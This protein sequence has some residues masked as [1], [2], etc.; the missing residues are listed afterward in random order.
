[1]A[2]AI[3]DELILR[4]DDKKRNALIAAS[5]YN[6][7]METDKCLSEKEMRDAIGRRDYSYDGRFVYAVITTGVYCRPNC[8]ARPARPENI[9]F[10]ETGEEAVAAGYR[11]CKRCRPDDPNRDVTQM[12]ELARFIEVH[13][14]QKLTLSQLARR[15]G[16]SPAY[17]QR[18]FK[19]I[20][21]VSPKEYQDE[22]RKR[23]FKS[24]LRQNE[25]VTGA[26]YEA[27][28]GS[29][30][31]VYGEAKRTVGMTPSVYRDGG[32]G[33]EIYFATRMTAFGLLMMAA[34]KRGVC[35]A[36]FDDTEETLLIQLKQEFPNATILP[37]DS[38]DSPLLDEWITRLNQHLSENKPHSEIPLDLQG[39]VFQIKV[40]RFLLSVPKGAVVSYSEVAKGIEEPSAIRAAAS[41][42]GKNRVAILVP[43]HRVLRSDGG[44][45]GYRWGVERKR[46]LLD[47]ERRSISA[48]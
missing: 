44:I 8:A 20:F 30:S 26:I 25:S 14:D 33:E 7:P 23:R 21:S 48:L 41:A 17:L 3:S 42:C 29:P 6:R 37:S 40:W 46:A 45:G 5:D 19:S 22:I 36:M 4:F 35:F 24:L 9:R 43:C 39:T 31:R 16:L 15:Q 47:L 34:T 32:L 28:Y 38:K 12:T 13:A 1:M 27:G 2:T 18:M 11:P 10:Y